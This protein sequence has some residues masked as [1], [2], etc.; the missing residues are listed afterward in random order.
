M[1]LIKLEIFLMNIIKKSKFIDVKLLKSI[2]LCKK[3]S[4]LFH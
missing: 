2:D 1:L 3:D 4:N